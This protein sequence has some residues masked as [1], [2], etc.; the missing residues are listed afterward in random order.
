[1]RLG[2]S[3]LR[4]SQSRA[5]PPVLPYP[6]W[7]GPPGGHSLAE[8][9]KDPDDD[10]TGLQATGSCLQG[11]KQRVSTRE[12]RAS[13]KV[14]NAHG[15]EGTR[16]DPGGSEPSWGS[17]PGSG[18]SK[19]SRGHGLAGFAGGGWKWNPLS[20]GPGQANWLRFE[21]GTCCQGPVGY[22]ILTPRTA[23]IHFKFPT[24]SAK[25]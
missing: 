14:G 6:V 21:P 8:V 24:Q 23:V 15:A 9:P 3:G 5:G 19:D 17:C 20:N 10:H 25:K 11:K 16:A 22:S 1:M 13:D 4:A 2:L 12:P 7:Q 18:S